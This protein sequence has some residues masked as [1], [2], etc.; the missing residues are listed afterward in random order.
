MRSHI[1]SGAF[2]PMATLAANSSSTPCKCFPG[3]A[4]WPSQTQWDL[5]NTTVSG[6]LVATTPLGSPCHDPTYDAETCAS[7]QDQWLYSGI[8]M[9]SSSS[10]MAPLFANQSCDPFTAEYVPCTLGNYVR[11]AVNATGPEDIIAAVEFAKEKN[12]RLVIRNTGHDYLGRSTGAG[13]L[14]V[15]TH[16]LKSIESLDWTDDGSY[17]GKALKVGAGVQGFEA[18]AAAQ[19]L[20]LVMVTGECPTVGLA[21][22][23][24]QGGGH[25]ALSTVFGLA[26]DNTLSFDVVTAAGELVTASRTQNTDLYWALSGGGGGNYGVVVSLTVQAHPDTT[27]SGVS[28]VISADANQTTDQIFDAVD[29]YHESVIDIVDSGVM[30]IYYFGTGFLQLPAV[31]AYNKTKDE[32]EQIISPFVSRVESL[33]L[34]YTINYTEFSSYYD[35]YDH[36]WGPLPLGNIQVGTSLY[37]GRLILR[38]QIGGISQAS[39]DLAAEGTT[40]I[41]VS[42]NVSRFGGDNAVLPQWRET[43]VHATLALPWN[44]SAPWSDD[45]AQQAHVTDVVVPIIETVTPGSGAY[46]NEADWA[47]P[48]FQEVFFGSNYETL[49]QIKDKWDPSDLFYATAAVGSDA[50]TVTS[51]GRLCS[52]SQ[53]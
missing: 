26:A 34:A 8:H 10:V 2:L 20:G 9:S 38:D 6:R 16:Y 47:Q 53:S 5:L 19:Q 24:T 1:L 35:H 25:S 28:L 43:I 40:F 17:T 39:R 18:L 14:G 11:Y 42:T 30:S 29:A 51:D 27:I 45:L 48:D 23:Y 41:G 50:Y 12:I 15:W 44:N 4:C 21:G 22:G 36:Y 32:L 3:D 37:G 49:L 46:M 7:L 52:V 13:S 31:T 33:G